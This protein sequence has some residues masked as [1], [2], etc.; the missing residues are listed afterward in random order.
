VLNLFAYTG[1]FSVHAAAGG[2]RS[3][4]SVD[5]STTYLDWAERNLRL[6]GLSGPTHRQLRADVTAW[7]AGEA[8]RSSFDLIVLDPPTFSNSKRMDD[9]FDVQRDHVPLI[10]HAMRTL[11]DDGTL[12]FSTN[13]KRFRLEEDALEGIQVA[14][15]THRTVPTDFERSKPHRSWELRHSP[16]R[17]RR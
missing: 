4:L 16:Y 13:R 15:T 3:T 5:L 10:R 7:L 11:R 9:T 1:T 6:N 17:A 2:A 12:F 14:E 8:P